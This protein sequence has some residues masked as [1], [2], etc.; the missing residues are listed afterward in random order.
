M[1]VHEI[2]SAPSM[3]DVLVWD[4]KEKRW[5]IGHR[6]DVIP[7]ADEFWIVGHV[8]DASAKV[9]DDEPLSVFMTVT[10]W[11]PLPMKVEG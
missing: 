7:G 8:A 4:A 10:H 2:S 9:I 11:S 5:D 3:T 1:I 6:R